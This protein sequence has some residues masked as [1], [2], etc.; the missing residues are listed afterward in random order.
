VRVNWR[1][2]AIPDADRQNLTTLAIISSAPSEADRP[3][4]ESSVDFLACYRIHSSS[5]VKHYQSVA[6]L[7]DNDAAGIW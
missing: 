6:E 7:T 5:S 4:T 3:P 1:S 2:A